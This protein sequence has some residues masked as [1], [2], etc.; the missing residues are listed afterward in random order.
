MI[1]I[2]GSVILAC[3]LAQPAW[4]GDPA[5]PG[6]V[7]S[8]GIEGGGYW[9]AGQRLQAAAS[10]MGLDITTQASS[11]SV[12]N[13]RELV[14]A[15]SPVSLAFTQAD[16]LHYY[17]D[18]KPDA[19]KVIGTLESIGKE[20]VFV[21]SGKKSKIKTDK[22]M[23]EAL[24]LQLGIKSP[25]SGIRVTFDHMSSLVPEL[26]NI[27]V[28]YGDTVELINDLVHPKSNVTK[29]VMVV[30]KPG[31]HSPEID[32]VIANP[33]K[34]RFVKLSDSRFMLPGPSGQPAYRSESVKPSAV[35][36]AG[37]VDT[38]C[39]EGLL[40]AN[41]TKL[42]PEQQGQLTSLIEQEWQQIRELDK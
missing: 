32:M 4:T 37:K 5:A 25:N 22:D 31:A 42:S 24:R 11:G 18:G 1:R 36:G 38:I 16:A 9:H 26:K 39:V 12:S 23:Q 17:L 27:T 20:C 7:I 14:K 8:T 30:Q 35:P 19:E 29:A 40:V 10:S 13:L 34:Y 15:D 21:I 28:H 2:L 33:D 41:R 6:I 3:L